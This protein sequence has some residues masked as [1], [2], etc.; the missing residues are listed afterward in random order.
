LTTIFQ[1][2]NQTPLLATAQEIYLYTHGYLLF[3]TTREWKY[4][5]IILSKANK[6]RK[7]R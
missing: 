2:E 4:K 5:A 1:K 3:Y 6:L 7:R